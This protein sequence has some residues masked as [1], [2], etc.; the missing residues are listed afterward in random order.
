[1]AKYS[2]L[3]GTIGNDFLQLKTT[4]GVY[5]RDLLEGEVF[6][7]ID[8]YNNEVS[9]LQRVLCYSFDSAE[10]TTSKVFSNDEFTR[11]GDL[12]RPQARAGFE[13]WETSIPVLRYGA[14]TKITRETLLQM[15][16]KNIREW[17]NAKMIADRKLIIKKILQNAITKVPS[18]A[19][20]EIRGI[21]ATPVPFWNDAEGMDTPR[22]NG[23]IIFTGDHQH[24]LAAN[25]TLGTNGANLD[26]LISLVTEH[27]GM[28]GQV[29]LFC[30]T[31]STANMIR[32]E[33]T[34]FR[35]I[36]VNPGIISE[37]GVNYSVSGFSQALIKG[38]VS[39]GYNIKVIGAWKE[40]LVIETAD[41]PEN[42]IFATVYTGENSPGAP[43][44]WRQHPTFKGLLLWNEDENNPIIGQ[45]AQYRRYLGVNV[46]N[47]DAGAVLYVGGGAWVEPTFN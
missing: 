39:L 3:H 14:G 11:L 42:Y 15:S 25:Q 35:A 40:A 22:P 23:Q 8:L 28:S 1:M 41:I 32:S 10:P 26:T 43:M 47:R 36:N 19:V 27:E 44:G 9:V 5:L 12:E 2:W 7:A 34:N 4:D 30:R 46:Q 31:G 16:S 20:D 33:T 45:N 24:F 18:P 13:H 29:L 17:A 6:P 38:S 21:T 37:T